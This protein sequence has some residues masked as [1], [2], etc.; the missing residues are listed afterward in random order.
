[1]LEIVE[2]R[3]LIIKVSLAG[4]AGIGL[5]SL[6]GFS[7]IWAGLDLGIYVILE[8]AAAIVLFLVF[9]RR[10]RTALGKI[11]REARYSP[12]RQGLVWLGLLAAAFLLYA[13]ES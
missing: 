1:L 9:L 11:V 3:D 4:P 12:G 8:T 5:S 13:G 7:W 10:E 2:T 6:A